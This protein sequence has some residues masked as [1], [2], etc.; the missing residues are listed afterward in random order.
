MELEVGSVFAGHRIEG[1]A[2]RGGMG[3]VYRA[4]HLALDHVVAMKVISAQL[5]GDEI[6]RE[7]FRS[8]SRI[9]VS[10]RHPNVVQIHHA[11]EENGLIFVTMDLIEG[12]DLRRLINKEGKVAPE[13]AVELVSQAAA[14]LD[15]AHAKG[16]V[17]RDVKPGNILLEQRAQ[18]EHAYLTDFGLT[19]RIEA[20]SGV[21]A[22]G[23]FVGTLDYVA[24]EQIKGARVDA[25]TDVYALG[26]VL[27][28]LLTGRPPFAGQ[29]EKVA[30]IYAHLQEDPPPLLARG[31]GIPEDLDAVIARALSKEPSERFPSAGDLARA[32]RA[33]LEAKPVTVAEH[34][35]AVGAAAP[36]SDPAATVASPPPS[37]VAAGAGGATVA[38]EPGDAASAAEADAPAK[39]PGP[40][41][42]ET[43]AAPKPQ[44]REGSR[45]PGTPAVLLGVVALVGAV[46][47]AAAISSGGGGSDSTA[48]STTSS[49]TANTPK[50]VDATSAGF[51]KVPGTPVNLTDGADVAGVWVANRIGG[52]VVRVDPNNGAAG[53]PIDVGSKPEGI[54]TGAGAV[55]VANA[56]D[57]TVQRI[58]PS[59]QG[60]TAGSPIP[61][62]TDPR[63]VAFGDGFV[64]VANSGSNSI[65]KIDPS[66]SQPTGTIDTGTEPHGLT[67]DGGFIY[68]V[69]RGGTVWKINDK[70]GQQ[71]AEGTVGNNPKDITLDAG[72][73]WISNTDD[74]T[75]S[76]LDQ[77]TLK[78]LGTVPIKP[79]SQPRGI[80]SGFGSVWVGL[81]VEGRVARIDP[82]AQTL[83]QRLQLK[84]VSDADGISAGPGGVWVTNGLSGGI[85]RVN[86][87]PATKTK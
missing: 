52:T 53:P 9:A 21:T 69:N 78:S 38:S 68:V 86:P 58:E 45:I 37:T 40:R 80:T 42:A 10:I 77:D 39:P 56:T 7:R 64:W 50:P 59:G 19:K 1:I 33:A 85:S 20:T 49:T 32:A 14:A 6:F 18:G 46:V 15:A 28:E 87:T 62:G 65:T 5:V 36:D 76:V 24:P 23:A 48:T 71:V 55:W 22:T 16:L 61:V 8:E 73:A 60:G 12:T 74:G 26:C 67:V 66:T 41:L 84:G 75:V 47:V 3:V 30:K 82:K 35:V 34:T 27:Y 63:A 4:T 11:G 57:N 51:T 2:G 17:H 72:N 70:S 54:A 81:G 25:R 79:A 31:R 83:E 13:R 29:E 43:I 44:R